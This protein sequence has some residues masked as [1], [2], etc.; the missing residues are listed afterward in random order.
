MTEAVYTHALFTAPAARCKRFRERL[1]RYVDP[2]AA[3]SILDIGCGT[4]E[5]LFELADALPRARLVGID[6][7]TPNVASARTR[8]AALGLERRVEFVAADYMERSLDTFDVVVSYSTL[9]LVRA[10]ARALFG[11]IASEIVPGGLFVNVMPYEC[12]YNAL[13]IAARRAMRCVRSPF[14][15][16]LVLAAAGALHGATYDREQLRER[17]EYM[18]RIP[19]I[20]GGPPLDRM[21]KDECGL[22]L[23]AELDEPHV[24]VAQPKHRFSVY[25]K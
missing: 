12:A 9:H 21:L 24:S 16:R 13:L 10:P 25:R 20:L 14:T 1:L 23:A 11:K 22:K 2:D 15:D 5:Q 6:I 4:G 3:C 18:Y 7:S 19:N 8:C 17:V